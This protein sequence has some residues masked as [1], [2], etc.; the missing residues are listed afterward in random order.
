MRDIKETMY[1]HSR[2]EKG[3]FVFEEKE[4]IKEE[5][6]DNNSL[7][8]QLEGLER[9]VKTLAEQINLIGKKLTTLSDNVRALS[10]VQRQQKIEIDKKVE[11]NDGSSW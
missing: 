1:A 8:F 3:E 2:D 6:D 9:K 7:H 10:S 5:N 11:R 4:I